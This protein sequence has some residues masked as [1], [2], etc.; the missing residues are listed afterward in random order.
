M[1]DSV[2]TGVAPVPPGTAP[3]LAAR[4]SEASHAS[5][6]DGMHLSFAIGAIAFACAISLALLVRSGERREGMASVHV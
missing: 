5:F 2:S 3:D 1:K 6:L 4:I